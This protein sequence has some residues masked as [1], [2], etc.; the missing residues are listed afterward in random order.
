MKDIQTISRK[1]YLGFNKIKGLS[2]FIN[3]EVFPLRDAINFENLRK[4]RRLMGFVKA[5]AAI[6]LRYNSCFDI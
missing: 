5:V 6:L 3:P 1:N 2:S 4:E